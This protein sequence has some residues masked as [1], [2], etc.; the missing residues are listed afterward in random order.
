M[1]NTMGMEWKIKRIEKYSK[2]INDKI[3]VAT[4]MLKR[5]KTE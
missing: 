4:T 3:C 5:G 2:K 1:C